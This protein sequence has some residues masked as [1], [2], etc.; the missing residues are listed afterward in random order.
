MI[1]NPPYGIPFLEVEEN[2]LANHFPETQKFADSY[3]LFMVQ[4]LRLLR[5]D[6]F[7]S[8]IVPNTFCDLENCD[9]FREWMLHG[10]TLQ[11]IWQSGWA[12][13]SAIVDTLVFRILKRRPRKSDRAQ[14]TIANREYTRAI[15]DFVHNELTKIDYRNSEDDR[16]LL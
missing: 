2:Y 6:G 5:D 16:R 15:G 7:L 11:D 10:Y 3:C 13:K 14:I 8:F 9:S 12:F 4:A 1:G